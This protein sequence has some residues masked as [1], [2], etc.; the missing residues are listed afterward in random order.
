MS[1]SPTEKYKREQ[2]GKCVFYLLYEMEFMLN[3]WGSTKGQRDGK[4]ISSELVLFSMMY[5][6][7]KQEVMGL[8][9]HLSGTEVR[10]FSF[11]YNL[12]K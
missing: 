8:L 5:S 9:G 10:W 1:V 11:F 7:L 3:Q 12:S 4:D 2:R 6:S